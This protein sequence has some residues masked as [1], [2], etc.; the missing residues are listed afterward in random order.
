MQP[1]GTAI[2]MGEA[3][4]GAMGNKLNDVGVRRVKVLLV[5]APEMKLALLLFVLATLLVNTPRCL[6]I[7]VNG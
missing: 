3:I 7:L 4:A 6:L 5:N 2:G 1:S